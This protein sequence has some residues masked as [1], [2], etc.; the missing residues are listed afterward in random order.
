MRKSAENAQ[1]RIAS[2]GATITNPDILRHALACG[3]LVPVLFGY[4]IVCGDI[5]L[6][7]STDIDKDYG[8]YGPG[9]ECGSR[10]TKY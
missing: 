3:R 7:T 4:L 10:C 1:T 5:R 6:S 2:C 8:G 9:P